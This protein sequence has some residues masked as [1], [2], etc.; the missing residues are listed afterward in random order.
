[1]GTNIDLPVYDGEYLATCSTEEIIEN[2]VRDEDRV[3]RNVIDE[4]VRRGDQIIDCLA[5]YAVPND[6]LEKKT[7]GYWW[8]RLHAVMILGLIPGEAAGLLLVDFIRNMCRDEDDNLQ[9]WFS[10]YWPALTGNKP[11][12]II[13]LLRDICMDRKI[14][15]FIRTDLTDV[16]I[17]D[18]LIQGGVALEQT[19]DWAAE[20]VADEE[21]DWDYRLCSANTLIDFPRE[22]YRELLDKLA[23]EQSGFGVHFDKKDIDKAY[24]KNKDQPGWER[25]NNP[26]RFYNPQ[27]IEMRQQ[28][29]REELYTEESETE[30]DHLLGNSLNFQYHEPYQRETPKIGRNDPCY[31]GSGKKYKKCCLNKDQV[32]V[33]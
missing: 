11:A 29:W 12:P 3:P 33:H 8:L 32:V 16:V 27:E 17:A 13:A 24:R 1:M 7:P 15:Y 26:W 30:L 10:G 4:C 5:P 28:R 14:D 25:F 9:E 19:L 31:C 21:E 20:L 6:E 22:R 23:A 18:A 2:M